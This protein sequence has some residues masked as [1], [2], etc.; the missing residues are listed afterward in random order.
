MILADSSVWIAHLRSP[1][2]E[3]ASTIQTGELLLHP[4]VIGEL[5]CGNL[6]GRRE[7]LHF[8]A[9]MPSAPVA[10][11]SE[12]LGFLESHSLMGKG[13]GFVDLH[14]LASTSLA[15]TALLWTRDKRLGKAASELGLAYEAKR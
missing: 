6:G 1:V 14:L 8:L 10:T 5:A 11:H 2:A 4:F 12:A 3:L 13:I 9:K 7:M 15:E